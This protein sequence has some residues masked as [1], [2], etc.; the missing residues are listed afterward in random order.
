MNEATCHTSGTLKCLRV[1]FSTS[2]ALSLS[3]SLYRFSVA[4]EQPTVS[5]E[6][7]KDR[8]EIKARFRLY[9]GE[10]LTAR[11]RLFAL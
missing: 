7:R 11:H 9:S 1:P 10:R 2:R 3:F 6:R 5:S 8:L 4:L